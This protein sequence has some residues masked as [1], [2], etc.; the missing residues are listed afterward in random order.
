[1]QTPMRA[2]ELH[3]STACHLP[4]YPETLRQATIVSGTFI[5]LIHCRCVLGCTF[6]WYGKIK[7]WE[8]L[9]TEKDWILVLVGGRGL[10]DGK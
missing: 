7:K 8:L 2:Y 9:H 4:S 3:S 6:R 5:A 1:M 10:L